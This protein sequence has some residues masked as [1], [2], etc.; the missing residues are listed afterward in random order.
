MNY[1]AQDTWQI[2]V[3]FPDPNSD[4]PMTLDMATTIQLDAWR[5]RRCIVCVGWMVMLWMSGWTKP[6]GPPLSMGDVRRIMGVGP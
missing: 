6:V 3:P 2:V 4:P 5:H 1:D